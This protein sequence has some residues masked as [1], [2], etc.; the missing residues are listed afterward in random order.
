MK[1]SDVINAWINGNSAR[2][3][4]LS[5]DGCLLY[6]YKLV[7]GR[8]L[9]GGRNIVLDYTSPYCFRSQTTSCHVGLAKRAVHLS[10]ILDP[11]DTEWFDVPAY[12]RRA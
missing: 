10:D 5:T 8:K 2:T 7:I 6:S 9:F 4:N 3:Q 11:R 1:N 12:L